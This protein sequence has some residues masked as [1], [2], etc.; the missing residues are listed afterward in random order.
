MRRLMRLACGGRFALGAA[1]QGHADRIEGSIA[2][3]PFT[4]LPSPPRR[5]AL[6]LALCAGLCAGVGVA[7]GAAADAGDPGSVRRLVA[8]GRLDEALQRL[9]ALPAPRTPAMR[10]TEG[11][12]L[13]D[14][15]RDTEASG[16]FEALAQDFPEL[17]EPHV[18]LA[19]L[20]A[21]AGRLDAARAALET[22]LRNDPSHALARLNL[23][24]VYLALAVRAWE[25]AAA[26]RPDDERLRRRL[27]LAREL[28][29][30]G[31]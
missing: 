13:I 3:V 9:R 6:A 4:S 28:A 2:A 10:F 20:H 5:R 23:G 18:N 21:R 31:R 26:A 11:V 29:A 22:A 12:I 15:G 27:A 16:V 19:T 17:P 14:L 30:P 25:A 1:L 7:W 8:E 24:E